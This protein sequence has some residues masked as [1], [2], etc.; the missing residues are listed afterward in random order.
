M[1][2]VKWIL[3][4][5]LILIFGSAFVYA[6]TNFNVY[7]PGNAGWV[8]SGVNIH[9]A[10]TLIISASGLVSGAYGVPPCDP[11]DGPG[12]GPAN[13]NY[14]ATGLE[15]YSLVGKIA[16]NPP[17]Q[18]GSRYIAISAYNGTL[19]LAYNNEEYSDNSGVYTVN[20]SVNSPG[21]VITDDI[22]TNTTWYK[23]NNPYIINSNSI[24][25][26][27]GATLTMEPGVEVRLEKYSLFGYGKI[28]AIGT[29]LDSI[30][31]TSNL[32]NPNPGD[33]GRIWVKG[34]D[35][36]NSE[37]K[38]CKI[39]FAD[40]GICFKKTLSKISNS[41]I[42]FCHRTGVEIDSCSS[43]IEYN[44]IKNIDHEGVYI[45]SGAPKINGN[46]IYGNA[47]GIVTDISSATIQNNVIYNNSVYG[48]DNRNANS[49]GTSALIIN[50]TVDNNGSNNINCDNSSPII[51]NNI[52]TNCSG[53]GGIRA[54]SDGKPINTFNN[55]WNNRINYWS[56]GGTS[57][58]GEGSISENP[59]FLDVAS[60]NFKL[61]DSSP[62]IRAATL[63]DC[64]ITDIDGIQRGNPPDMGAYENISDGDQSLPVELS[65]F[66]AEYFDHA[67]ILT[68]ITFS[69]LNN[70]GFELFKKSKKESNYHLLADY[71]SHS[72]LRGLNLSNEAKLYKFADNKIE[73]GNTYE[74]KLVQVDNSGF[75][76]EYPPIEIQIYIFEG[77][78]VP[79]S[80]TIYPNY[81]NPFNSE[82][83]IKY[84]IPKAGNIKIGI[85]NYSG[86]LV[87][88]A[89]NY[90]ADSGFYEF[91]WNATDY[92]GN[93][94]TSGIYVFC[95]NMSGDLRSMKLIYLK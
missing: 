11:P 47:N 81:P 76:K 60:K 40:V 21:T 8:N 9:S 36:N 6:S 55:V 59:R 69:E 23:S 16:N 35:S 66:K 80:L 20:G 43:I 3:I 27:A 52:I 91:C 61:L 94:V 71:L 70:L 58:P 84:F 77:I 90:C 10:D 72:E 63:I 13:N 12:Y 5:F 25:I 64:P 85:F 32:A 48:I 18:V 39:Q 2:S 4:N 68:W 29:E 24:T 15:R 78:K 62:C 54:T 50:N 51:K 34:S 28:I 73:K 37:F 7:V 44:I 79:N 46:K 74:Y 14:L 83:R 26:T 1:K 38:F 49:A 31:F 93:V 92:L 56:H 57:Q 45:P 53:D 67:V 95:I 19:F 17:F 75:K 65:S 89:T 82:T 86:Q 30:K 41:V 42:E 87:K 33:W 88:E 22:I